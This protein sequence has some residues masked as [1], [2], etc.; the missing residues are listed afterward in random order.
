A[1]P[2]E[3]LLVVHQEADRHH[4]HAVRFDR[5]DPVVEHAGRR[6]RAQHERAVRAVDVGVDDAHGASGQAQRHRQVHGDRGLADA[7]LAGRD[8]D[9]LLHLGDEIF[10]SGL[11]LPVAVR[12]R[13]LSRPRRLPGAHL[14]LHLRHAGHAPDGSGGHAVHGRLRRRR[15]GGERQGEGD[16]RVGD[17]QVANEPERDDILLRVRILHRSQRIQHSV[18]GDHRGEYTGASNAFNVIARITSIYARNLAFSSLTC[19]KKRVISADEFRHTLSH[20][21]SGVTVITV[22][23]KDGRPTGLTASAFTSV[24]LDP[25]LILVCVDHKS[26][27][28]P[29]LVA[30]KQFAVNV[31]CHDQEGVSR[32]F[33][34]TKIENK[35]EGVAFTLSALGLPLLALPLLTTA[36]AHL[37]SATITANIGA[38]PSIFMGRVERARTGAGPP[39]VYYR[40]RYDRLSGATT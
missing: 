1:A 10:G 20:F 34:T 35:F 36:L 18:L 14:H 28:Y 23:D 2:D 11:R 5:D 13:R 38:A 16:L 27:S 29:A 24:S 17:R 21:A 37:E 30:G 25:P 3:R 15:L 6:A 33:A 22:C 4:L 12:V 31:L 40:G 26:Q 32:R 39:L 9:G 19:Y 7:A 8:G